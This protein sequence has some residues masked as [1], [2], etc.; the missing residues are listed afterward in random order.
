MALLSKLGIYLAILAVGFSGGYIFKDKT[1]KQIDYDKIRKQVSEEVAKIPK[2]ECPA[3]VELN[4]FD[5]EKLNN[6]KGH[7]HLHN[8]ISDVRIVI[9]S[10]DS[11]LIKQMLKAAK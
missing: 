1:T 6:K 10:K 7:F 5:V 2:V 11:T 4:N 8:T 9:E 3:A